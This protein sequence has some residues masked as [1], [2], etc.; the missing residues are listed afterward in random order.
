[1]L[2]HTPYFERVT[3]TYVEVIE[4]GKMETFTIAYYM[5]DAPCS[6]TSHIGRLL[7]YPVSTPSIC[8]KRVSSIQ[9]VSTRKYKLTFFSFT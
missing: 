3:S 1:M 7:F 2:V 8:R 4:W 5:E 6:S 9:I